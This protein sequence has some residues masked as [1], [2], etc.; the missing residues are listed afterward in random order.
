MKARAR[1]ALYW[2]NINKDIEEAARRCPVCQK[3]RPRNA[4]MPLMSHEIPSLPWQVVGADFLY[5]NGKEYLVVVDFYSFFFEIREVQS[6]SAK[7]VISAFADIFATHGFPQQLCTDNGP[8]FTS[9][10]FRDFVGKVGTNHVCSSPYH[11]RSNGMA[12]RAVQEAKKLLNK[13]PFGSVDFCAALLEWRNS[14]RDPRLQSPVQRLMGR[15]TRTLLPVPATHL[16]PRLIPPKDVQQRLQQIRQRQRTF[17]NRSSKP[18]PELPLG[19]SVAVYNVPAKTWYPAEVVQTASTPRSYI[20]ET[21]DG[22]QLQR[23][24]EHL[25]PAH[26]PPAPVCAPSDAV[27]PASASPQQSE[28]QPLRRS[29]RERRAPKRYPEK[30][31]SCA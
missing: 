13:Y 27:V 29:Q 26:P 30:D 5:N 24:R 16:Q 6:T 10:Q 15:L 1:T 7:N 12:E 20:V 21:E 22:R 28:P 25:R 31:F 18:L 2:P 9:Q 19:S 3:H 14:P 17:Y 11:P 8:P 23:T 4:R